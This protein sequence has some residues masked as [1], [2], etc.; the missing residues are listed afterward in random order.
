MGA[1]AC[2]L[3]LCVTV[4]VVTGAS[5]GPP[6]MEQRVMRR[7]AG[8]EGLDGYAEE[9][10]APLAEASGPRNR[11]LGDWGAPDLSGPEGAPWA[12]TA[13]AVSGFLPPSLPGDRGQSWRGS[14]WGTWSRRATTQVLGCSGELRAAAVSAAPAPAVPQWGAACP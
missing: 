9:P 1:P 6:G 2:A 3:A 5:S 11:R 12:G 13:G 4:A 14:L 8:K 7:A 10:A